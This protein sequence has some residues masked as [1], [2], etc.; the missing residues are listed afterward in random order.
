[1]KQIEDEK[2]SQIQENNANNE[3]SQ[4][5]DAPRQNV[6]EPSQAVLPPIQPSELSMKQSLQRFLQKRKARMATTSPYSQKKLL[7]LSLS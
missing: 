4:H 3:M 2:K 1:M 5:N 6:S 7:S